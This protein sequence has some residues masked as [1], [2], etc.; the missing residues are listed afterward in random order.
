MHVHTSAA[1][2]H[3]H[4]M[5]FHSCLLN[6]LATHHRE[7]ETTTAA[8]K[9]DS[10]TRRRMSFMLRGSPRT[11]TTSRL[12]MWYCFS[13]CSAPEC[14]GRGIQRAGECVRA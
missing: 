10:G 6:C 1:V 2:T 12:L 13:R 14:R 11:C 7:S 3:T 4:S 9:A 5:P 8:L